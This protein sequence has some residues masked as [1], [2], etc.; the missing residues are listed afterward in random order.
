MGPVSGTPST[1]TTGTWNP[2]NESQDKTEDILLVL[3]GK[4]YPVSTS[5]LMNCEISNFLR[6]AYATI[7]THSR[8]KSTDT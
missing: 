6:I 1:K 5:N 8:H 7:V 2:F 4:K 3:S